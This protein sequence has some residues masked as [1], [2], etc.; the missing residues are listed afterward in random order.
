MYPD[1]KIEI[2]LRYT[3]ILV[4]LLYLYALSGIH[5]CI[6]ALLL[7]ADYPVSGLLKL[8]LE[9]IIDNPP[10]CITED[11]WSDWY[12]VLLLSQARMKES[13]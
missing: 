13:F 2:A 6:R 3:A 7:E 4:G 12:Q 8:F 10:N 5:L 11:T 1:T 9:F